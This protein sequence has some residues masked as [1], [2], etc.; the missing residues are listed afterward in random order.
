[1]LRGSRHNTELDPLHNSIRSQLSQTLDGCL[2]FKSQYVDLFF[3]DTEADVQQIL[4]IVFVR[5]SFNETVLLNTANW[6][7]PWNRITIFPQTPVNAGYCANETSREQCI[8]WRPKQTSSLST[9]A[10]K[11][12]LRNEDHW[13]L[14]KTIM[15]RTLCTVFMEVAIKHHYSYVI[16]MIF[17]FNFTQTFSMQFVFCINM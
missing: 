7:G 12:M 15:S 16:T 17:T 3:W 9:T 10:R 2:S 11:V 4:A 13:R 14:W 8:T 6:A 1:M 5:R